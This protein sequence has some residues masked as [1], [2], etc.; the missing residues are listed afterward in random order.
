MI[1]LCNKRYACGLIN[2]I[3]PLCLFCVVVSLQLKAQDTVSL[4]TVEV[5]A[6]KS[7]LSQIGK[8]T[9]ALDSVV[10]EQFRFSSVADLIAFNSP[11]FIK[12]YGPGALA[13]T[14]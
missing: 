9:Q 4:R 12:S 3:K 1:V 13:T 5:V 10:K 7:S 6:R 2:F 11:V 8:K 14:A